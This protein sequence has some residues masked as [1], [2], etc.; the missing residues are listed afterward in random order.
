MRYTSNDLKRLFRILTPFVA[1]AVYFGITTFSVLIKEKDI[2][3]FE[4]KRSISFIAIVLIIDYIIKL[5]SPNST[6]RIWL[7]ELSVFGIF[8][9]LSESHL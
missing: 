7:I 8:Y 6:L 4:V 1:F 2:T 5:K 9:F 3:W